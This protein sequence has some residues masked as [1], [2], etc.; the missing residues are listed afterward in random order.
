MVSLPNKDGSLLLV[1]WLRKD[2]SV[3]AVNF[4]Q[5]TQM[6]RIFFWLTFAKKTVYYESVKL[7]STGI[8][9]DYRPCETKSDRLQ[10]G[11]L[12]STYR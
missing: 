7:V 12:P 6:L 5:F 3:R 4:E 10:W 8:S 2:P 1:S 9:L 11:C